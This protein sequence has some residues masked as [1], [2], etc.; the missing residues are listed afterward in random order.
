MKVRKFTGP[1]G[2]EALRLARHTLGPDAVVLSTRSIVGGVELL[3]I[4][5]RDMSA[6]IAGGLATVR[7]TGAAA[8]PSEAIPASAPRVPLRDLPRLRGE[9]PAGGT[10][11][12]NLPEAEPPSARVV[13]LAPA[14]P[15]PTAA[16]A[17]S[18]PSPV[19]P[20]VDGVA[21]PLAAPTSPPL[22]ETLAVEMKSLRSLLERE[23]AS[24]GAT[25]RSA[26][27]AQ[28][29][30]LTA[31]VRALKAAL[32]QQLGSL[33]QAA[34]AQVALAARAREAERTALANEVQ[35]I[36]AL[37]QRE[38][39][40]LAWRDSA[41]RQ[42][43]RT[44]LM[45]RLLASGFGPRFARRLLDGLPADL[46]TGTAS[47]WLRDQ[48][49]TAIPTLGADEIVEAGGVYALV[50]PTGVGKTTTLAKLASRCAL[51]YGASRLAIITTDGYRVGAYDQ[52]R[53]YAKILGVTLHAVQDPQALAAIVAGLGDRHLVLVDTAGMSQRDARLPAELAALDA[54]GA[55]RLVLLNAAAQPE[56]LEDVA[57][58]YG[59][60]LAAGSILTKVDEAVKI[61]AALD[62]VSRHG[63]PLAYIANG[64]RVPEDLHAPSVPYLAHRALRPAGDEA[65][66]LGEDEFG[67]VAR[68]PG[69][70]EHA[71]R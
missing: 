3:A 25:A 23:L 30:A 6:L 60:A 19:A 29:A 8:P 1:H 9:L 42:P 48:V 45:R 44:E 51:R 56:Q 49:S 58:V 67:L 18:P 59:A 53:A 17:A 61:G 20:A 36:R 65:F 34:A 4:A 16:L 31:E 39:A 47:G 43:L 32:E 5:E 55:R 10:L 33:S 15:V 7:D 13:P 70:E 40:P 63:L 35:A 28:G 66:A 54:A 12:R 27:A 57:R 22:D 37:I 62:C 52:L 21:P 26:P 2:R 46:D 64:Q 38:I 50:G 11:P 14:T 24:L 68:A 41:Q 71:A 69:G